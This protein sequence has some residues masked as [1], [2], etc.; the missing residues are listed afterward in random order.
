M[1]SNLIHFFGQ[2]HPAV[3]H[4]PVA[5][6]MTAA[7]AEGVRVI[8]KKESFGTAAGFA[9]SLGTLSAV[10]ATALGWALAFTTRPDPDL[11]QTLFLH[12]WI[13]T[14]TAVWALI[15]LALWIGSLPTEKRKLRMAYQVALLVGAGLVAFTGHLGGLLVYGL[16]YFTGL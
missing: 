6:L 9:L 15:T 16:D 8:T 3:I 14:G 12:R 4:F 10:V 11:K 1:A 13:G 7:A 5:L 2:F